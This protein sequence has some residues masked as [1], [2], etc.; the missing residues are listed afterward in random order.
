[1]SIPTI[2][3]EGISKLRREMQA[4]K[5]IAKRARDSAFMLQC[6]ARD[7]EAKVAACAAAIREKG[8]VVRW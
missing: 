6:K 4:L 7:A 2:D 3:R 1:M 8:G 5:G